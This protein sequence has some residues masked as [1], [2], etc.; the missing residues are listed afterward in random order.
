MID[1]L[2]YPRKASRLTDLVTPLKP[3]EAMAQRR[4]VA[5]SNVGGHRELISHGETGFLFAPD[6]P[7]DCAGALSDLLNGREEWDAI[8]TRGLEHVRTHHDWHFNARRYHDVYHLLLAHLNGHG[9]TPPLAREQGL[10][11]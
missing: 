3:L 4:I 6:S 9:G 5:A 1:V 8:R 7:Q 2:T 11:A 10:R